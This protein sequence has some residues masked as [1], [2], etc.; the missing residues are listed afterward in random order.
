MRHRLSTAILL[1][2]V[3]LERG[4]AQTT[5]VTPGAAQGQP[6]RVSEA[7]YGP[8]TFVE[9][10]TI[11]FSESYQGRHVI[12]EGE[13]SSLQPGR[14]WTVGR[15][16]TKLLLIPGNHFDAT[17]LDRAIGRRVQVRGIVRKLRPKEY[18]P[19]PN[20][21]KVDLDLLEDP[22][23]PVL[24]APSSSLPRISITAF[25]LI[26]RTYDGTFKREPSHGGIGRQ[27]L[28]DPASHVGKKA[29]ILGQFRG[30]NLFGD[31]PEGSARTP[32]DW[33]LKDGDTAMWVTGKAP[34]G[35]GWKLDPAYKGD[36]KSWLEVEGK[37][38]VVKGIVY[39]NASFVMMTKT[40][41]DAKVEPS[42]R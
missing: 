17:D 10:E 27:I 40:P 5:I 32:D 34:K 29:R 14:S 18:L 15:A 12:T 24:P 16:G 26:D 4:Q 22:I 30:R 21:Q 8:P 19:G 33:V 7:N 38:E 25:A 20:G 39:I 28:D 1:L 9:I 42:P 11:D 41:P 6:G 13:I 3:F 23:L 2:L 35:N 37:P 36:T 31:L